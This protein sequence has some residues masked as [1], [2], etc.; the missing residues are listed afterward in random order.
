M[1]GAAAA[2]ALLCL[3][4]SFAEPQDLAF[5]G[6]V[7]WQLTLSPPPVQLPAFDDEQVYVVMGDGSIRAFD[8]ATGTSRWTA[9]AVSTVRP[10]ASN[11]RLAGADGAT[12][13]VI[14][15]D[16]GAVAWTDPREPC[17]T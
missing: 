15:A 16:S 5:P 11:R 12:A 6:G 10:A 3:L 1:R 7:I 9:H 4:P 17:V 13:W 8:H 14:D 2:A